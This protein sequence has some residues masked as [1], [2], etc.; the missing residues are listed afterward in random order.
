MC[1]ITNRYNTERWLAFL[2]T[3]LSVVHPQHEVVIEIAKFLVPV[4][5][6]APNRRTSEFPVNLVKRKLELAQWY[7]N[8]TNVVDPGYSK[9]RV[10]VL[11]EVVETKLFLTFQESND[12]D[13][14]KD[15]LESSKK[16]LLSIVEVFDK[17]EPD[18]GFETM[19]AQASLNLAKQCS[20]ILGQIKADQFLPQKWKEGRWSLLEM[21]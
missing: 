18:K 21:C 10:K 4:L 12:I 14:V 5:C 6:R 15:I 8:V 20:M 17:L 3:A 7:L 13:F 1:G 11:Y 19:I 16:D 2:D 9:Q